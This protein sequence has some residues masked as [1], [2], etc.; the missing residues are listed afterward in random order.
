M[1]HGCRHKTCMTLGIKLVIKI[2]PLFFLACLLLSGCNPFGA[3]RPTSDEI[4]SANWAPNPDKPK[5]KKQLFC[6]RTLGEPMCYDHELDE[7]EHH[8]LIGKTAEPQ[9]KDPAKS[10]FSSWVPSALR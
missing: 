5:P 1:V 4:Q 8:R 6:Y 2:M 3:F 10:I 7:S 9:E